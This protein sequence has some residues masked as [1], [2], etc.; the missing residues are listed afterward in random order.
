MHAALAAAAKVDARTTYS[1]STTR[2]GALTVA[3]VDGIQAQCRSYAARAGMRCTI[4][5]MYGTL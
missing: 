5:T 4:E 2:T 1:V 3:Q